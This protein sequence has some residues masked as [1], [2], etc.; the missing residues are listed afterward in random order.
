MENIPIP[1]IV[2]EYQF[3]DYN[4]SCNTNPDALTTPIVPQ[5]F[6]AGPVRVTENHILFQQQVRDETI[7]KKQLLIEA[8]ENKLDDLP[9]SNQDQI[10][11]IKT[12]ISDL[13][14]SIANY[15]RMT[16]EENMIY[17]G[18]EKKNKNV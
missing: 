6:V 14:K 18:C 4:P 11:E 12:R 9:L 5:Q 2:T 17:F 1:S 7:K 16:M 10:E 8:Y 3:P 13:Q 15:K